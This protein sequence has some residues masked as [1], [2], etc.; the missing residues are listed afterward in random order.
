LFSQEFQD[1][2]DG[3][4]T[5]LTVV[6]NFSHVKPSG[7]AADVYNTTIIFCRKKKIPQ[8]FFCPLLF[9]PVIFLPSCNFMY[10][11]KSCESFFD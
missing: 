7:L 6:V 11:I 2:P 1:L 9:P 3:A 10:L 5:T 8:S 4:E